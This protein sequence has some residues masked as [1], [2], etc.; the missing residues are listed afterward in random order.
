MLYP[1]FRPTYSKVLQTIITINSNLILGAASIKL[2]KEQPYQIKYCQFKNM[3]FF[4][5]KINEIHY[6]RILKQK[7]TF[8]KQKKYICK[9]KN[10]EK[11][12]FS[13]MIEKCSKHFF[14]SKTLFNFVL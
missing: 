10:V 11:K 5:L 4:L 7:T 1:I 12:Y 13:E 3:R 8:Y 9:Q 6:L 14:F 2:R